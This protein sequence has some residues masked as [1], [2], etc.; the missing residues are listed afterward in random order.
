MNYS[1][2]NKFFYCFG[3]NFNE[4]ENY[5]QRI[6]ANLGLFIGISMLLIVVTV[7]TLRIGHQKIL[8]YKGEEPELIS[9]LN[10]VLTNTI[11][12][13][14]VFVSLL[15]AGIVLNPLNWPETHYA[16]IVRL[17]IFAR[18]LYAAGYVLGYLTS[19]PE[20][21]A[22]GTPGIIMADLNIILAFAGIDMLQKIANLPLP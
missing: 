17:F 15:Y 1:L 11:E 21:R 3:L 2:E 7:I 19:I 5:V 6:W 18:V 20:L 22:V 12:S 13:T 16:H 8:P 14:F 10:R 9:V 4:S